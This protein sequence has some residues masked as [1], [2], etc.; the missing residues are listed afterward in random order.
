MPPRRKENFWNPQS[1]WGQVAGNIL[2]EWVQMVGL[3]FLTKRLV[4]SA[5]N[6]AGNE[7]SLSSVYVG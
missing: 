4:E 2:S 3:A 1:K 7:R 6:K 5:P